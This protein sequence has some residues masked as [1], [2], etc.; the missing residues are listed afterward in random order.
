MLIHCKKNNNKT[1]LFIVLGLL[2]F[3]CRLHAEVYPASKSQKLFKKQSF[4]IP[5]EWRICS[6]P[7]GPKFLMSVY[8]TTFNTT[9]QTE[10]GPMPFWKRFTWAKDAIIRIRCAELKSSKVFNELLKNKTNPIMLFGTARYMLSHNYPQ[11]TRRES[12][13]ILNFILKAKHAFGP[14][15]LG[16][17]FGEWSW[18]GVNGAKPVKELT[19]TIKLFNIPAPKNSD[20]ATKWWNMEWDLIFKKYQDADIPVYSFN[21]SSLNHYECRKGTSYTGNEIA[22]ANPAMDSIFI[23]FCRG[24]ARQYSLPWGVYAAEFPHS[25]YMQRYHPD[26]LR[27][28]S[29][30]LLGP[31]SGSPLQQA[32]RTLYTAYMAG[33]NFFQRETD[34]NT[35]MLAGYDLKNIAQT[36]P[37]ITA[38]RDKDKIYAGP[39]A[40]MCN[41]FYENIVKKHD[42]GTPYTPIALMLDKNHG[43]VL[44]YSKTLALGAV[45]YT[46][47]EEQ[48][49]AIINT[50]SPNEDDCYAAGSFGEIF[51]VITTEASS[52]VINSYRALILA[53]RV[54]VD[55]Q[56]AKLLQKFVENGGL[57]FT[58]CEQMTPEL[59][60][61]AGINDTGQMG[62]SSSYLRANDSGAYN[63]GAYDYHKVKLTGAQALFLTNNHDNRIWPVVTVNRVGKGAV[64]VATPV[65][66]NVKGNPSRMHNLFTTIMTMITDELVPVKVHGNKIKIMFNRNKNGW[67]VTLMNHKGL[68]STNPSRKLEKREYNT[69]VLKPKFEY[70]EATEWLTEQKLLGNKKINLT[71]PSGKIRI[72]EFK[73]K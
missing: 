6:L 22:Y 9:I 38:L 41:D 27:I 68:T 58:T 19:S 51:D 55:K 11:Y 69:V 47:A 3:G 59:W 64:V 32:Q 21:C 25:Y 17:D 53:G 57:L 71:I 56:T 18:G 73:I 4:S 61:L 13:E 8:Y 63:C 1:V 40:W 66:L 50:I 54:R 72:I 62:K 52:R 14:R 42:R 7:T 48:I 2:I 70:S 5:S 10:D 44:H 30:R 29:G 12:N 15:F 39:Y 35:G 20:E 31:S 16:L 37:R 26:E 34:T 23:A 65:W 24:A 33:T 60:K 46:A 28:K 49:R 45:P 43:F 67:V 36:N